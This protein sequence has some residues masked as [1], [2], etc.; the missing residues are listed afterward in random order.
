MKGLTIVVFLL[1]VAGAAY[2]QRLENPDQRPSLIMGMGYSWMN[3]RCETTVA[4]YV[5]DAIR[6]AT[7]DV[8]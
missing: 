5:I 8:G 3:D 7:G 2:G 1:V 6:A 4:P